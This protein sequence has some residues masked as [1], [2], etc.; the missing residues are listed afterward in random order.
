MSFKLSY[1]P[2]AKQTPAP[3]SSFEYPF[4]HI[5]QITIFFI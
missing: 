2:S 1:L 5:Y 4:D 3:L